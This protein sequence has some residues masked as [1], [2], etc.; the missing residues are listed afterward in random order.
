MRDKQAAARDALARSG[1][2][3]LLHQY[4]PTLVS[5]IFVGLDIDGSDID[6]LCEFDSAGSFCRDFSAAFGLK[7]GYALAPG[8]GRV[9]GRFQQS[10]FDVE[11]YASTTPV[12][13]QAGLRHYRVMQRLVNTGG[14]SF[15]SAVRA[16]KTKGLKTEP[17]IG[18]LLGLSG[19]PYEA[20][21]AI[22]GWS[23][24]EVRERLAARHQ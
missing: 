10:G 12:H 22:E 5:T 24:A 3:R 1:V 13:E 8:H 4:R 2:I 9:V 20:V 11:V 23:D 7:A 16:L 21:L 17:A 14:E 6:V 15:Q 19:D 18:E